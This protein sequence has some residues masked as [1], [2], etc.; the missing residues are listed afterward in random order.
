MIISHQH[1]FIF[2]KTRKTAGSSIEK[3]LVNYLGPTDICTGSKADGTPRINT[4]EINGHRSWQWIANTYPKE[5]E[6][7]YKFAVERNPWDKLISAYFYYKKRKPKKVAKGFEAFVRG[8]KDQNDWGMY[9]HARNIKVDNLIDYTNLHE[10]FLEMPI[11]YNNELLRTF[12]KSDTSRE[13]DYKKMYN[14]ETKNI[15]AERFSNVIKHF[16]YNF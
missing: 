12:V 7:Y 4:N 9:A 15:V 1:K 2:V 8:A 5:W 13:K 10:S 3:Y 14:E 16:S 6:T 11:P